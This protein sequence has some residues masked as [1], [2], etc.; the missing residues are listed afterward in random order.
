MKYDLTEK[1]KLGED[2][3]LVVKGVELT[4]NSDATAVMQMMDV[5]QHE[6]AI[7]AAQKA[8][9][10]LLTEKDRKKLAELHLKM[11]DYLTVMQTAVKLAMGDDPEED[12]T[13][14]E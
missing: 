2:P 1:L 5:F 9:D 12:A 3:V 13:A 6:S 14:G 7:A 4:V 8:A 11:D 10:L